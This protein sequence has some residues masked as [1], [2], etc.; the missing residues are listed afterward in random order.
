METRYGNNARDLRLTGLIPKR[1][2]SWIQIPKKE[3]RG[4]K[5]GSGNTVTELP[6]LQT[7]QSAP[8][9]HP[10]WVLYSSGT[11]GLPKPIVHG[12]GGIV[13]EHCKA[14]V[15][16]NDIK[17]DDRFYWYSSTGW[18]MWNYLIFWHVRRQL[19]H[20]PLPPRRIG[21]RARVSAPL[22]LVPLHGR[23]ARARSAR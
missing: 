7:P 13:L 5:I 8:A 3:G 18:M 15:F 4:Q 10:L 17:P 6:I 2:G 9:C 1:S 16:H 14:L 23:R 22:L 12:H 21:E 11:T 19:G 20:L